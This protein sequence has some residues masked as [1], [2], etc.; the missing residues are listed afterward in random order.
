MSDFQMRLGLRST[1][2]KRRPF[3]L[4][5]GTLAVGLWLTAA[6]ASA[7]V[8]TTMQ[9]EGTLR[10]AGGG[11]AADG[12]YKLTFALFDVEKAGTALWSE[13]PVDVALAGGRFSYSLGKTKALTAQVLGLKGV[14][15]EIKVGTDPPLARQA[16]ASV[17]YALSASAVD[18][19]GCI[20]TKQMKFDGDL[21]LT[22]YVIKATKL[23]ANDV[24]GGTISAQ[25]FIG[26][27]SALTGIKSG[28]GFT[29]KTCSKGNVVVGVDK[30]GNLQCASS[31][32]ALPIDGLETISNG[33]LSNKFTDILVS[34]KVPVPIPD[35]VPIGVKDS[36]IVPDLGTAQ[37]FSISLDI[38]NSKVETLTVDLWDPNG[39]QY[40]L[41][42]GGA[43][44]KTLLATFPNPTK[45]VS[46]DLT[47]WKGKNLKGKW[48]LR[49]IDPHFK[50]NTTDGAINKWSINI[51][52][53]SN[54]KV[55]TKGNLVVTG[56]IELK[57][58]IIQGGLAQDLNEYPAFPKGSR[59]FIYGYIEDQ[60]STN[61]YTMPF[62]TYAANVGTSNQQLHDCCSEIRWGDG[63]GNI[64][65][66][67]GGSNGGGTSDRT[68]QILVAFVKNTTANDITHKICTYYSAYQNS[69]NYAGLAMNGSNKWTYTS[70]TVSNRCDSYPFPKSSTTV[71]VLKTGNR[72]WT[73]YS[74]SYYMRNLIGFYS[75]TWKLP[76]GLEWDYKRYNDWL[77]NK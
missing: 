15:L 55:L 30:D 60:M 31:G 24:V 39:K 68:A 62:Y 10:A 8:P 69:N 43:T 29:P 25:K 9:F 76:A 77:T 35:H 49:V 67:R 34:P 36:I 27:G 73:N 65:I 53:L 20:K 23:S 71:L 50:D 56:D 37:E 52:T 47:V 6:G 46:G 7:A 70:T 64:R 11:A 28:G 13:G 17:P 44:G 5:V 48:E 33:T 2:R 4:L 57:G 16:L 66:Q 19:T 21:D 54:K 45:P 38:S 40:T 26:D 3:T 12:A 42:K 58:K 63:N 61:Y 22:G 14:W 74:S 51:Q 1:H 72:Y 59:P 32:A 18:C 41:F 75:N